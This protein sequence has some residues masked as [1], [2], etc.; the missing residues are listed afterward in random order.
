MNDNSVPHLMGGGIASDARGSVSFVNPFNF[1][2]VKRFY[3]IENAVMGLPRAWHGHRTEHKF[4]Y[5]ASG[6]A[7]ICAAHMDT[8]RVLRF[9]MDEATPAVL[10]IPA[11]WANGSM[12]LEPNTKIIHFSTVSLKESEGDD[13]RSPLDAFVDVWHSEVEGAG[14]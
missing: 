9:V 13:E 6:R 12:S 4:V 10:H 11:G 1:S 7:V 5:V 3:V 2:G 14:L 8:G